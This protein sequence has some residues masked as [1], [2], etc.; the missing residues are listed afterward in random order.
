MKVSFEKE[1]LLAY[2][3]EVLGIYASGHPLEQYEALW[4][5]NITALSSDFAVDDETGQADKLTDQS[6]VRIGGIVENVT[7]KYTKNGKP[8][9]FLQVEDLVGSVEVLVFPRV[10]EQYRACCA[11]DARIFVSGKVSLEDNKDAKLLADR[12][13]S[14]AEVPRDLWLRFP[15]V[16]AYRAGEKQVLDLLQ[17]VRVQHIPRRLAS[18]D[19]YELGALE[20]DILRRS[21]LPRQYGLGVHIRRMVFCDHVF[22]S[23]S[24]I[25]SDSAPSGGV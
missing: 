14:F 3:K 1:Q 13:C 22:I 19:E 20:D 10:F 11:K 16:D 18:G 25:S 23:A 12:L 4:R 24:P 2:E 6:V 15:S 5:K 21:D 7:S 8:M 17:P 9:A